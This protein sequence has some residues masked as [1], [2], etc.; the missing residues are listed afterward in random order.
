M[1]LHRLKHW[2]KEKMGKN[3]DFWEMKG[4]KNIHRS[5]KDISGKTQKLI[6]S[7]IKE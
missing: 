2:S 7:R 1:A 6:C 3:F 5:G 4:G